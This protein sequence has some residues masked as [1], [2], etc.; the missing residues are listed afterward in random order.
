MSD[1]YFS[2]GVSDLLKCES[3]RAAVIFAFSV[4]ESMVSDLIN[5]KTRH[6]KSYS[7]LSM[8]V[9]LN[10]L[11]EMNEI[12]DLEYESISW[13]RKQRNKAAHSPGFVV[14]KTQI[15]DRWIMQDLRG[16]GPLQKY[17]ITV[18]GS[19]WNSRPELRA[20]FDT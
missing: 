17:L 5:L 12:T 16:L 1:E 4:I 20:N 18:V 14:D 11:H 13:L 9:K 8:Q 3:E 10:L 19:F 6:P 2:E 7:Q 15:Q